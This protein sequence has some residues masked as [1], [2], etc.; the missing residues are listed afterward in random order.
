MKELDELI[1]LLEADIPANPNSP[2]ALKLAND[3]EKDLRKYFKNLSS[4]MP[5]FSEIYYKYVRA[6]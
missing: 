2:K 6:E 3:L 1:D 4:M 5:D